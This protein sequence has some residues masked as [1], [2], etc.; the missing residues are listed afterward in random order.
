MRQRTALVFAVTSR[1]QNVIPLFRFIILTEWFQF[2]YEYERFFKTKEKYEAVV[3]SKQIMSIK[4]R[5]FDNPIFKCFED[6]CH[7]NI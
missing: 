7:K 5:C 3:S 6:L 2:N 1:P 4:E